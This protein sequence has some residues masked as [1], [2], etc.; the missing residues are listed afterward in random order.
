MRKRAKQ[1]PALASE[2][3]PDDRQLITALARGLAL[4]RLLAKGEVL[5]T[6]DL[7]RLSGLSNSTVSRL[8]YTLT[9]L[10][11]VEYLSDIG[12]YRLGDAC[13]SLGYLYMASD[14][15]TRIARPLMHELAAFSRVP[16]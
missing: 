11:Y 16:V 2:D 4:L 6:T 9:N 13:L 12:K 1:S 3:D 14:I 7:A 8:C 15:V 5:G 10:R